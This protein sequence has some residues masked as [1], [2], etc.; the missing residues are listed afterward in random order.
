MDRSLRPANHQNDLSLGPQ[1]DLFCPMV[2]DIVKAF[3]S[4]LLITKKFSKMLNINSNL[5][6]QINIA[7]VAV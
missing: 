7:V 5:V 1:T 2:T 6:L 4:I 3:E